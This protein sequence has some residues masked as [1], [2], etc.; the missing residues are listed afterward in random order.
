MP[1][2]NHVS[3]AYMTRP[4]ALWMMWTKALS[5]ALRSRYCRSEL[6][7]AAMRLDCFIVDPFFVTTAALLSFRGGS[8]RFSRRRFK[9]SRSLVIRPDSLPTCGEWRTQVVNRM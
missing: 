1:V 6:Q 2:R 4:G 7:P 3:C 8:C 9:V 5:E